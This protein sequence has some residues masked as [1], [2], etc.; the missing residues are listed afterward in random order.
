MCLSKNK[1]T[2]K[3]SIIYQ[4]RGAIDIYMAQSI[5]QSINQS[6]KQASKQARKQPQPISGSVG[7]WS[8]L[9]LRW[10]DSNFFNL[11]SSQQKAWQ[12]NDIEDLRQRIIWLEDQLRELRAQVAEQRTS[13]DTPKMVSRKSVCTVYEHACMLVHV[14]VTWVWM[15]ARLSCFQ[16]KRDTQK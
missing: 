14:H 6:S 1:Q 5:S 13:G 16:T 12:P 8:F 2:N 11:L 10:K 15:C 4:T 9:L 7:G 3:K